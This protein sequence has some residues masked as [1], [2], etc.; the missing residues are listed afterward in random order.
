M[1]FSDRCGFLGGSR[2]W[3]LQVR[4]H[5][6]R[7][8]AGPA[9]R[10][11]AII[12]GLRGLGARLRGN[13]VGATAVFLALVL[14]GLIGLAGLGT[15][16]ASWYFTKRAMQGAA[17]A[18]ATTAAA[19]LAAG[20]PSS[21]LA[22]EAKS[23]A[24]GYKFVDGSH[25]TTVTVNYPP[26]SGTYQSSPA[27]EVLIAQPQNR[28]LSALFIPT[29]PT[30]STR[31]VALADY[32]KTGQACV[33][34]LDPANVT[35]VTTSGSTALDFPGCSLYVN[36]PSPS[37]LTMNGGATIDA[38]TA[39]FVGGV[40]GTG[41]TTA[42]GT[43]TGVDPLI[44]PYLNAAV[45][46]YSGCNSTNYKL[47]A[48]AS[49][50]KSAGSSGVYV[51]CKGVTLLGGSSLTL[52]AGTFI[53]DQGL[54]DIGGGGT[55]TATSGT[56]II[57]TTSSPTKSCATTKIDGGAVLSITAPTSGAL[58]GIAI[59]QDR[60]CTDP[61]AT[62][63]LTGGG[64]QNIIG[65][66]YF[67]GEAVIYSGGSP[68]GGAVCTQLIAWTI[69]FSGGSTFN[70]NCTGTGTRSVSLTGGRLVE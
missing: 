51:F 16:A 59:Y 32:S 1:A 49:D 19:A 64:T 42:N 33:V 41:L 4:T 5:A 15:E 70:N 53:I 26:Q 55:L 46:P 44:D 35:T 67:P 47:T 17:D 11:K 52:G 2:G 34:A 36:S 10:V 28:L 43:Y 23:I 37:A 56:T 6:V 20:A 60:A 68:T 63:S 8:P 39:Y 18:G 27:V 9:A 50:T 25:G 48:G 24:A 29:G 57:L 38:S 30:I 62:N 54:L 69:A 7:R 21:T 14:S 40:S 22:T 65:A 45:P 12:A 13:C 58:S 61:S 66:I 3:K 31:A